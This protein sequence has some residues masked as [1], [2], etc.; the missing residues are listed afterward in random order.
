M[1]GSMSCC[2]DGSRQGFTDCQRGDH[3][4]TEALELGNAPVVETGYGIAHANDT[5]V[6]LAG[7][8]DRHARAIGEVGSRKY[9]RIHGP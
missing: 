9:R 5:E 6:T 8:I 2:G 7:F 3:R 1:R 4:N